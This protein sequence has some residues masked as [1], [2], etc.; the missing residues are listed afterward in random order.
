MDRLKRPSKL[1]AFR[2]ATLTSQIDKSVLLMEGASK[3]A[4][5]QAVVNR[6]YDAPSLPGGHRFTI[7]IDPG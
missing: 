6:A 3:M 4:K 7:M 1:P 2:A 5:F